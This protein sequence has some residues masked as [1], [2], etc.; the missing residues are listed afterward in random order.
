MNRLDIL[1]C[2][3]GMKL[4]AQTLA[5]EVDMLKMAIEDDNLQCVLTTEG[6]KLK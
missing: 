6:E 1:T 2:L 3:D 5:N 4:T